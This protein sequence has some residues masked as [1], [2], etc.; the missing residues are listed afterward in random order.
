MTKIEKRPKLIDWM[1]CDDIRREMNRKL[2]LVGVYQDIIGVPNLPFTL[3]QLSILTKWDTSKASIKNF[4]MKI[5]QPDKNMIGPVIGELESSLED[6]QR[7]F[8]QVG[9]TPFQIPVAGKYEIV[10]KINKRTHKVGTFEVALM[11]EKS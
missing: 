2:T 8:I 4:E 11:S 1:I 10:M 9:I 5:I 3:P 7:T 6:K